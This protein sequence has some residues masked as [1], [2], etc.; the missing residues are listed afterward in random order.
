MSYVSAPIITELHQEIPA[1]NGCRP[2][3]ADLHLASYTHNEQKNQ[4]GSAPFCFNYCCGFINTFKK[5]KKSESTEGEIW[6]SPERRSL[7]SMKPEGSDRNAS[8]AAPISPT[9]GRGGH[10][11]PVRGHEPRWGPVWPLCIF[12]TRITKGA[13]GEPG[14]VIFKM[15]TVR[16]PW[17][18]WAGDCART[19]RHVPK[20]LII[21]R[22]F[23]F[24]W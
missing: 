5:E 3:R 23:L 8:P 24:F 20:T 4:R 11:R 16:D 15:S 21:S 10:M 17:R 6:A 14:G 12:Q 1:L 9:R 13:R 22:I 7:F 2:Q 18:W 19:P